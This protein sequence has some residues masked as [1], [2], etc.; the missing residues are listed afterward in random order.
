MN[1]FSNKDPLSKASW[2]EKDFDSMGWHDATI[3]AVKYD[4]KSRRLEFDIDYI[5]QWV[6]PLTPGG[7]YRFWVAPATLIF[8]DATKPKEPLVD[9]GPEEYTDILDL[10]R[11]AASNQ[12]YKWKLQIWKFDTSEG[13][14]SFEA[15]GYNQYF[16]QAPIL[17]NHSAIGLDKRGG[18]SFDIKPYK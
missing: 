10:E 18:I 13:E 11:K 12:G 2:S 6:D 7:N 14:I 1:L 9:F 17:L 15:K 8:H 5:A 16:R 4:E 3:Y